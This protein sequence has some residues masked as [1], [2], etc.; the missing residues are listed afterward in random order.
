M[1]VNK[2]RGDGQFLR[3]DYVETQTGAVFSVLCDGVENAQVLAWLRYIRA[4]EGLAKVST[5][6]ALRE[7]EAEELDAPGWAQWC[8][9]LDARIWAI[10]VESILHHYR[11]EDWESS[12]RTATGG[13]RYFAAARQVVD[14][15]ALPCGEFGFSGSL[16]LGACH[17]KSDLDLVVYG[18]QLFGHVQA[19]VS[20]LPAEKRPNE[21]QWLEFYRGRDPETPFEEYLRHE[22]R[23]ANKFTWDGIRVDVTCLDVLPQPVLASGR[24]LGRVT[25]DAVVAD[26][27]HA[28]NCPALLGIDHRDAEYVLIT[29]PTYAGQAMQGE[30]IEVRGWLEE[31]AGFRRILVGTSREAQGEYIRVLD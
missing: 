12:R 16:C 2:L 30:R 8:R 4:E 18:K 10:P 1:L 7:M 21:S 15:L 31:C 9:K 11:P 17:A 27:T 28:F 25:L 14:F 6:A 26:D 23:K 24:K 22:I 19:R 5:D 20:K 29:T 3:K 13:E